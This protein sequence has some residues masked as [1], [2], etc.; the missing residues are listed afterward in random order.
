MKVGNLETDVREIGVMDMNIERKKL[1]NEL[2]SFCIKFNLFKG[3]I[4]KSDIEVGLEAG[5][6]KIEFIENLITMII[7]KSRYNTIT[8]LKQLKYI[9]LE[10]ERL[11]LDLEYK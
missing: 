4:E 1:V 2:T 9:L 3:R 7:Y 6:E 11:R 10:L 8:D 5:L